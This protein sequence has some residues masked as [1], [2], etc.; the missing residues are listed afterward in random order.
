MSDDP[1]LFGALGFLEPI[2]EC[3]SS[4]TLP[5][6]MYHAIEESV[7]L[8]HDLRLDPPAA[9]QYKLAPAASNKGTLHTFFRHNRPNS[10]N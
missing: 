4:S 6:D 2:V 9:S 5:Y 10:I 1:C 7:H 3:G 8:L